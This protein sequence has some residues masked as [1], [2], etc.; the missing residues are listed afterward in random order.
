MDPG[1]FHSIMAAAVISIRTAALATVFAFICGGAL[2]WFCSGRRSWAIA[3]LEGAISLPLVLPPTVLGFYLLLVFGRGSWPGRLICAMMNTD[4]IFTP[5]A[6]VIAATVAAV[7]LI[8]KTIKGFLEIANP[9]LLNAARLDGA[10]EIR[11]FFSIRLPMAYKGVLSGITLAFLRAI[12]EFGATLMIAGNIPGRT[13]T[14]SLALWG[15][16]MNGK[17]VE[18]H[19]LALLLVIICLVA[20]IGLRKL[21]YTIHTSH[22]P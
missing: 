13:Q 6:A 9:D 10:T 16:V 4:I 7:P 22:R 17:I 8:F 12:G 18:A 20:V 2:A 21:D 3:L 19:I 11:L 1:F 14:L 5:A 15:S